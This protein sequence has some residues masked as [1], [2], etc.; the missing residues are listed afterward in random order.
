MV[1]TSLL[2]VLS[3]MQ[4]KVEGS[5][6]SMSKQFEALQQGFSGLAAQVE[7]LKSL[8]VDNIRN[9]NAC[10]EDKDAQNPISEP[11]VLESI[12]RLCKLVR[13]NATTLC[14]TEADEVIDDIETLIDSISEHVSYS[15]RVPPSRKRSISTV[16][17]NEMDCRALKRIKGLLTS[18]SSIDINQQSLPSA[19]CL[20]LE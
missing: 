10:K 18:S 1:N 7:A 9:D 17:D 19:S 4:Q 15:R 6:E 8:Q 16:E 20:H 3:A 11:E 5:P 13:Y 14:D 12:S 2:A